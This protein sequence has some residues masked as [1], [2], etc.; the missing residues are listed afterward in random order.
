MPC[1]LVQLPRSWVLACFFLIAAVF[2]KY[3]F[4][5]LDTPIMKKNYWQLLLGFLLFFLSSSILYA[6]VEI[7][8]NGIDDDTDGLI[9]EYDPD[10]CDHPNLDD[11]YDPCSSTDCSFRGDLTVIDLELLFESTEEDYSPLCTPMF[12]DIDGD[13]VVE[14]VVFKQEEISNAIHIIDGNANTIEEI[15]P[16]STNGDNRFGALALGDVLRLDGNNN[17]I[18]GTDGR[19]E[20]I[21]SIGGDEV[22]ILTPT[23]TLSGN[24]G[25]Y[26]LHRRVENVLLNLTSPSNIPATNSV[27]GAMTPNIAD[28]DQD[29]IPEIYC[30]FLL[31]DPATGVVMNTQ[32]V[33]NL[34]GLGVVRTV[35]QVYRASYTAAVEALDASTTDPSGTACGGACDGL[36][37]VAG[38]TVYA[39]AIN[40][41]SVGNPTATLTAINNATDAQGAIMRDGFTSI[42]DWDNDGDVDAIITT[43]N[44]SND[45]SELYVWDLQTTAVMGGVNVAYPVGS[46]GL[47]S[48][49]RANVGDMDG[50][51]RLEAVYCE[52]SALVAIDN[53]YTPMWGFPATPFIITADGSGATGTSMFDFNADGQLEVVYRDQDKLRIISGLTGDDIQIVDCLS[54]TGLEYPTVGDVNGDGTTE[55][56]TICDID[57]DPFTFEGQLKAFNPA[58]TPWAPSRNVWNQMNYSYTNINDDLS[59]PVIQQNHYVIPSLNNYLNQYSDTLFRVPDATGELDEAFCNLNTESITITLDVSNLGD[60]FLGQ[61]MPISVYRSNP[62]TASST[63][64]ALLV[65][66]IPTPLDL[67]IQIATGGTATVTFQVA[68]A[69]YAAQYFILLNDNGFNAATPDSFPYNPN[70]PYA[71]NIAECNYTN[72]LI[73]VDHPS[74]C[75]AAAS[76]DYTK[77]E[78]AQGE[79]TVTIAGFHE[80][81]PDKVFIPD[82]VTVIVEDGA[83]LDIT[84]ADVVFGIGAGIEVREDAQLQAYNSVFRPCDDAETWRGILF[85]SGNAGMEGSIKECTFLNAEAAIRIDQP[86]NA[87]LAEVELK[88]NLFTNCYVG[89]QVDYVVAEPNIQVSGNTFEWGDWD[90]INYL[91]LPNNIAFVGIEWTNTGENFANNFYPITQNSFVNNTDYSSTI[92]G[93]TV[94]GILVQAGDADLNAS[95]NQFTNL[96]YAFKV[97]AGSEEGNPTIRFENN[98]IEVTRRSNR[99]LQYQIE[100][101]RADPIFSVVAYISGNTIVNSAVV[102]AT[103]L[104]PTVGFFNNGLIGTGAIYSNNSAHI[105]DNYIRGFEVGIF[106]D[107]S[108]KGAATQPIRISNNKIES[109]V[110]GIY[111]K[112]FSAVTHTVI[113]CNEIDMKQT[114]DEESINSVGICYQI[115]VPAPNG[116]RGAGYRNPSFGFISDNCVSNTDMAIQLVN[117]SNLV[118]GTNLPPSLRVEN[119]FMQNFHRVGL[120]VHDFEH[121][122]GNG[123]FIRRNTFFS[124]NKANGAIDIGRTLTLVAAGA[125]TFDV[126]ANDYGTTQIAWTK[127]NIRSTEV[128]PSSATCAGQDAGPES[129]LEFVDCNDEDILGEALTP[130]E[131]ANVTGGTSSATT[132]PSGLPFPVVGQYTSQ[133]LV[134][135][136]NSKTT[137]LYIFPNPTSDELTINFE[138]VLKGAKVLTIYNAQGQVV[139]TVE[140]SDSPLQKTIA[141]QE[142]TTGVYQIV[143]MDSR[144]LA[145]TSKFVKK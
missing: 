103:L 41:P 38:Y 16:V 57:N 94:G 28:F 76:P 133:A 105:V 113:T 83:I 47:R 6:Q 12:G 101:T 115:D 134:R 61:T 26:V 65:T 110:Y 129:S 53:N 87:T 96:N 45:N 43:I 95:N 145:G 111:R 93:H 78:P 49:G 132:T 64:P 128:E 136:A 82:G 13:G 116:T 86:N 17:V 58:N 79:T 119:N 40:R 142:L 14:I 11:F 36:E 21:I 90:H 3:Y 137:D 106:A 44:A 62:F 139:K 70:R 124:N 138:E 77:I 56:L 91:I 46:S 127:V 104:T 143:L 100:I 2:L 4:T 80:I 33:N 48:V 67:G 9:D 35:S 98:F 29:G 54:S 8:G 30:G 69:D 25:R 19:A 24:T 42:A 135:D 89:L 34:E 131:L 59:V 1:S 74:C 75:F 97:V 63:N 92:N 125:T 112:G 114:Q 37:L 50:D 121:A 99:D 120:D 123:E 126:H 140:F 22:L 7:C 23:G 55:V 84:N 32:A 15:I 5:P 31:I 27:E 141:V 72:N 52:N 85:T 107:G 71:S 68:A 130:A 102:D 60:R 10:C 81:W 108:A 109:F 18:G 73:V 51:G 66:T 88:N 39:V 144:G 122:A 118:M 20:I 117:S